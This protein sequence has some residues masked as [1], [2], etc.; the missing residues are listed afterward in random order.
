MSSITQAITLLGV[1]LPKLRAETANADALTGFVA[2][3]PYGAPSPH[4]WVA[5]L[6]LPWVVELLNRAGMLPERLHD[7]V[8]LDGDLGRAQD[9]P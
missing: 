9:V 6:P 1:A 2:V 7:D 8:S 5:V 3:R 4:G